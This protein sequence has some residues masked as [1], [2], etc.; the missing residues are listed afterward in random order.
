MEDNNKQDSSN[1]AHN[2]YT[3]KVDI[4]G[5][6]MDYHQITTHSDYVD[7]FMKRYIGQVTWYDKK[8]VANKNLF[9]WY[10]R[11]VIFLGAL[12]PIIVAVGGYISWVK[13]YSGLMSAIISGVI[14]IVAALDKLQ[15]P[16]SNWYNYRNIAENLKKEQ[17]YYE[18]KIPPYQ[19]LNEMAMKRLFVER[20]EGTVA[21]DINRFL[22][23]S[24]NKDDEDDTPTDDVL[25]N[26]PSPTP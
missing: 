13:E 5:Q 19:G 23:G 9:M 11:I 14:A 20:I 6:Q 2:P 4:Y 25:R 18:F 1:S 17:Y 16:M 3:I 22:Q 8:A 7:Y 12:I 15:Q 26:T 24:K 10:Q 21:S